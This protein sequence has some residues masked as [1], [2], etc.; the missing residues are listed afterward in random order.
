MKHEPE[1]KFFFQIGTFIIHKKQLTS[2]VAVN[3][4][5]EPRY[6]TSI[7]HLVTPLKRYNTRTYSLGE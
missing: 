6:C 3:F 4:I 1:V 2:R 5:D 7:K